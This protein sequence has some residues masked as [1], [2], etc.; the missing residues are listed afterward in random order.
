MSLE[1]SFE[2]IQGRFERFLVEYFGTMIGKNNR[3]VGIR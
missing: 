1:T 3:R 2:Q